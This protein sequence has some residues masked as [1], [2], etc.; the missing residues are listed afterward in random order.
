MRHYLGAFIFACLQ[1]R[2]GWWASLCRP[3]FSF[4]IMPTL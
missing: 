3:N 2:L 4:R 1:H